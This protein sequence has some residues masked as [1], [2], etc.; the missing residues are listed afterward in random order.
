MKKFKHLKMKENNKTLDKSHFIYYRKQI[1]SSTVVAKWAAAS[2]D[3]R[4]HIH[5]HNQVHNYWLDKASNRPYPPY[6]FAFIK[7]PFH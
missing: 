7:I 3:P 1:V 5:V 6:F 4:S 2:H